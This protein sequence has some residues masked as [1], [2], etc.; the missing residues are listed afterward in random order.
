[1]SVFLCMVHAIFEDSLVFI[2]LGA[3]VLWVVGFRLLWALVVTAAMGAAATALARRR[4][5]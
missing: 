2:A 3:S 5:G 4:R 1:M